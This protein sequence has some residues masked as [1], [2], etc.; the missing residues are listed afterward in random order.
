MSAANIILRWL[1]RIQSPEINMDKINTITGKIIIIA[2]ELVNQ[3]NIAFSF[4]PFN[5]M[6]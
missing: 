2:V 4:Q 6:I 3:S 5:N 1:F